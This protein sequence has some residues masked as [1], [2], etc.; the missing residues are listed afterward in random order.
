MN[1][2]PLFH[3]DGKPTGI[4]ACGQCRAVHQH[5]AT[6]VQCCEDRKCPDCGTQQY[7]GRCSP[8]RHIEDVKR[9][10]ARFEKAEKITDYSGP[11][12]VD[13]DEY[14]RDISD[15]LEAVAE[16]GEDIEEGEEKPERRAYVWACHSR[17]VCSLD[18]D[19]VIEH[20]TQDAYEDF[21]PD[22]LSGKAELKAA[23][24]AFNEKNRDVL[25]YEPDFKRAVLIN[26]P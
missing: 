11:V 7:G 10:A 17:P 8:C 3:E 20:A 19:S 22:D 23:L 5:N 18:V 4:F 12:Y 25:V 26:I 15:Y 14:H 21:T 2:F 24:E 6:A 9:E 13:D 1:P 16:R